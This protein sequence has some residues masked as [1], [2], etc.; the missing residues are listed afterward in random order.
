M[1]INVTKSN[2]MGDNE[3]TYIITRNGM[4]NTKKNTETRDIM[5]GR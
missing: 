5:I 2:I 3:K 4:L 1:K